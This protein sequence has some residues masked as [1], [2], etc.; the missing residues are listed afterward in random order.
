M[1]LVPDTEQQ[2]ELWL[3][4]HLP[5]QAM[6]M[7]H[8]Y[9]QLF[10]GQLCAHDWNAMYM[11]FAVASRNLVE[12]LTNEDRSNTNF[13]VCDFIAGGFAAPSIET[14]MKQVRAQIFHLDKARPADAGDK[15]QMTSAKAVVNWVE[16]TLTKFR[17]NLSLDDQKLWNSS[18]APEVYDGLTLKLQNAPFSAC[19]AEPFVATSTFSPRNV[20]K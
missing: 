12:F 3:R 6:M 16:T 20:E 7:R 8:T 10:N 9:S 2:K 15:F 4:E 17:N 19:T 18:L 1:A 14:L 5:Y 13:G 11:A